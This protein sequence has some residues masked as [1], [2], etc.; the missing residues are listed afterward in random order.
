MKNAAAMTISFPQRLIRHIHY[1]L[2]SL[3]AQAQTAEVRRALRDAGVSQAESITTFTSPAELTTLYELACKCSPGGAALEIGSY[4]GASACY[5][6]AGL[7]EVGGKLYCVD[8]WQNETMPDGERDTLAEF[9]H[10]TNGVTPLL[11]LIRKR[12]DQLTLDDVPQKLDL[13]FIDGDHSYESVKADFHRVAP[14]LSDTGVVAFH[15]HYFWKSVSRFI[16][17]VLATGDWAVEGKR[18]N[19][20]WLKRSRFTEGF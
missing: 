12:V 10:N 18:E 11:F 13:I 2:S 3:S 14:W 6:A 5:I 19:L 16:G 17:E 15:D 8:T 20:I 9:K 1:R 7:R 4:L